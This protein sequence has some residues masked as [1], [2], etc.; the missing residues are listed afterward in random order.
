MLLGSC[1][2]LL[3]AV[4]KLGGV[5]VSRSLLEPQQLALGLA[6]SRC[7]PKNLPNEEVCQVSYFIQLLQRPCKR[8]PNFKNQKMKA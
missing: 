5:A 7:L 3:L 2:S 1:P 6:Q 4:S 8:D